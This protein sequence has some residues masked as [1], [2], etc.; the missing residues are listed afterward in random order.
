MVYGL[1]LILQTF[2]SNFRFQQP[3]ALDLVI[4]VPSQLSG[5]LAAQL[6]FRRLELIV[7][8]VISALS[9]VKRQVPYPRTQHR[10]NLVPR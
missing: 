2:T 9:E 1:I 6:P 10:V 4:Q 8:I 5:V 7:H 3:F